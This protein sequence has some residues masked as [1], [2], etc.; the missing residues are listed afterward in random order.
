[1]ILIDDVLSPEKMLKNPEFTSQDQ[2]ILI[3]KILDFAERLSAMKSEFEIVGADLELAKIAEQAK[4][5]GLDTQENKEAVDAFM[6]L[7]MKNRN[8]L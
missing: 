6:A 2:V 8:N 5:E 4:E 3:E 1:M 7:L